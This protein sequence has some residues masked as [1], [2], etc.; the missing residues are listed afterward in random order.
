MRWKYRFMFENEQFYQYTYARESDELDGIIQYDKITCR[1]TLIK[2]CSTDSS[3]IGA[4]LSARKALE[5]FYSVIERGF[6]E[7]CYVCCG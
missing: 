5:H 4:E 2:L 6:P 1:R 7:Y 3:E